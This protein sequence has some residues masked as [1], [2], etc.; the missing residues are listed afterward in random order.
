MSI[1]VAIRTS[2]AVVFAT[3]S[4][5]TTSGLVGY[6]EDGSP[7]FLEQTYDT[8]CKWAHDQSKTVMASIVGNP[9]IGLVSA[10]D[11]IL[12]AD[13]KMP[14]GD[15][16]RGVQVK[17][18]ISTISAMRAEHWQGLRV[19]EDQWPSTTLL[20]SAAFPKTTQPRTW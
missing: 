9:Q 10:L 1:A 19:P 7:N 12:A 13:L 20:L 4:K 16:G 17:H 15:V 2:T 14:D 6:N 8:A 3:D 18:L 11:F 5:L